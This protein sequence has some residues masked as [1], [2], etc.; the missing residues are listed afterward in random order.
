MEYTFENGKEIYKR[1]RLQIG[2]LYLSSQAYKVQST[3]ISKTYSSAFPLSSIY[4]TATESIPEEWMEDSGLTAD[5]FIKYW[6][7]IN[8]TE[9]PITPGHRN[10]SNPI[11][12]YINSPLSEDARDGIEENES[13]DFIDFP[14]DITTWKIKVMLT[15]PDNAMD[16][17]PVI[18]GYR[19]IYTYE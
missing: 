12:Y 3:H 8:N 5:N 2:P 17:T 13:C 15:R 9:Y 11:K 14:N 4:F 6:I 16:S 7:V 1:S 19:F 10:G 18:S